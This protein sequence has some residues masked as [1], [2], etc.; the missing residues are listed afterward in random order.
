V[1]EPAWEA[2]SNLFALI[3]FEAAAFAVDAAAAPTAFI[4]ADTLG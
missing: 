3:E 4:P 2:L 1:D